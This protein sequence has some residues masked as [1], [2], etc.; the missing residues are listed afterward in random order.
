MSMGSQSTKT[1]STRERLLAVASK[2]FA[3]K[4]YKSATVAEICKLA[5]ANIASI[6]YHFGGKENLYLEAMRYAFRQTLLAHP[7][8]GETNSASTPEKRLR[9]HIKALIRRVADPDLYF[10][11]IVQKE[12]ANPTKFL[13]EI[14]EKEIRPERDAMCRIIRDLLGNGATDEQVQF[15]QASIVSQCFHLREAQTMKSV[16]DIKNG[17]FVRLNTEDYAEHVVQFSLAGIEAVGKEISSSTNIPDTGT[18]GNK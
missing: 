2:V 13:G 12:K 4:G 14:F 3:N 17:P 7:S 5:N 10:F 1:E 18:R 15:C 11:S 9:A 8:A 16:L 6:N